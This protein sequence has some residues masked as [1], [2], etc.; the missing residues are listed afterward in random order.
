MPGCAS[1]ARISKAI[2]PA[3]MN[4]VNAV[5]RYRIPIC[6]ASVVRSNR[7]RAEPRVTGRTGQGRVTMGLGLVNVMVAIPEHVRQYPPASHTRRRLA[8][9]RFNAGS[10]LAPCKARSHRCVEVI[11][12][13]YSWRVERPAT[14]HPK[15]A[16]TMTRGKGR[17]RRRTMAQPTSPS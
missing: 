2:A 13:P 1:S 7:A 5:I 11:T 9:D 10:F 14:V 4:S 12:H 16:Q 3:I 6:F 15:G 8:V 17:Q